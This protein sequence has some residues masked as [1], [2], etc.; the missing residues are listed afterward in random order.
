M[1]RNTLNFVVD[2]IG[3]FLLIGLTATGGIMKW[4]L[5]PG[6]GGQHGGR[7]E[8]VKAFLSLGR[9]DWGSIHFWLSLSF[10][11]IV[12]IHLALHYNWI[13]GCFTRQQSH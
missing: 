12:L 7:G 6:S 4:V 2:M 5:P 10:I 3:F 13:K 11:A 8:H 9:H 1:K